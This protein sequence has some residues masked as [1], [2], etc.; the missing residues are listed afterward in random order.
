MSLIRNIMSSN[1]SNISVADL[2]RAVALRE[3]IEDLQRELAGILGEAPVADGRTGRRTLSASARERIAAAQRLRWAKHRRG[4]VA[5][6]A[7]KKRRQMSA[8]AR[9]RISESAKARW[10]KAKAKGQRT[11]AA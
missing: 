2:K 11:L 1:L 3:R 9:A 5:A 10:A 7:G 4:K 8:A 6:P